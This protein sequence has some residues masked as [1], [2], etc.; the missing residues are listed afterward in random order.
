MKIVD[1]V[2][3]LLILTAIVATFI[4]TVKLVLTGTL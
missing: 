4:G 3:L 2:S 1:Y